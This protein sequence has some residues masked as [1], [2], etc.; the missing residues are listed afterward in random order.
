MASNA[1]RDTHRS[2]NTVQVVR[3]IAREMVR[4]VR[5]LRSLGFQHA[6]PTGT[7]ANKSAMTI[8]T[9]CTRWSPQPKKTGTKLNDLKRQR[10][11]M[12][13]SAD[14]DTHRSFNTVQVVRYIAREMVRNV[15]FLRSLGFLRAIQAGTHST[16]LAT[17]HDH[18]DSLHALVVTAQRDWHK[19]K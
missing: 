9:R 6:I 16:K 15:R 8:Q 7:H 10:F 1:D 12:A 18:P 13:R 14:T 3:Y 4:N 2:F 11:A 17:N 19:A 5:F